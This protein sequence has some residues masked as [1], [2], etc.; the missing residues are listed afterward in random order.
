MRTQEYKRFGKTFQVGYFALYNDL[1]IRK[2]TSTN[3][4]ADL[5]NKIERP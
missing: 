1:A 3:A 2:R 5:Y 4:I